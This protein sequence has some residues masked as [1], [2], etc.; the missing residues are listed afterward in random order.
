MFHWQPEAL[1]LNG[2]QLK[3]DFDILIL[4]WRPSGGRPF[5]GRGRRFSMWRQLLMWCNNPSSRSSPCRCPR[6]PW[7]CRPSLSPCPT[8]VR[9][10]KRRRCSDALC[11]VRSVLAPNSKAKSPVRSV[12]LLLV[13]MPGAPSSICVLRGASKT[14]GFVPALDKWI[15]T[16]PT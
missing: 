7:S 11:P 1:D 10:R 13:A 6:R 12:L 4:G 16:L 5:C 14:P 15:R 9:L 2:K 3:R 8:E